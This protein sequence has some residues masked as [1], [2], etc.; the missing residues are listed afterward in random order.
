MV[1]VLCIGQYDIAGKFTT[2]Q[3]KCFIE[4]CKA[5]CNKVV[6]YA[7]IPYHTICKEFPSC[8]DI[9]IVE[10]PD[11]ALDVYAYKIDVT[12]TLFW[13]YIA[14]NNYNIDGL[15][16]I[17]HIFFFDSEKI[18]HRWKSLIMKTMSCWK[19]MLIRR[20]DC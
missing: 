5:E 9:C 10:K 18:L 8:C 13:D 20:I 1:E 4:W 3:W 17:S 2:F 7:Q 16:N 11:K 12:N 14:N 15:N 6:I 19:M